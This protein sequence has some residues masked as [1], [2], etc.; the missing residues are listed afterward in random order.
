M[1]MMKSLY[2]R[3]TLCSFSCIVHST[4]DDF[5]LFAEN[6]LCAIYWR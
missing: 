1:L 2:L 4:K 5:V 3:Y 6:N